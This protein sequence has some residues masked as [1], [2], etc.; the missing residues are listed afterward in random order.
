MGKSL[1]TFQSGASATLGRILSV[2]IVLGAF[3]LEGCGNDNPFL[4]P[5]SITNTIRSYS[6]Y[7]LTGTPASLPAAYSYTTESLERPQLL[8]NGAT[9]FDVAFDLAPGGGVNLIPVRVLIPLPPAGAPSVGIL[10]GTI[11]F[12]DLS[13]APDR[14]F[15]QDSIVMVNVGETAVLKLSG[16]GCIY[17][18]PYYAKV[19]VDSVIVAERRIVIRS[20]V[21]RNCGYRS[22]TEGLPKN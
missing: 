11:P 22:L 5:A 19:V 1:F 20:L 2:C 6:V 17:G 16:S 15:V 12:A 10:K 3:G 9:N 14:G 13:R 4:S 21:D 8:S 7:A 18:E